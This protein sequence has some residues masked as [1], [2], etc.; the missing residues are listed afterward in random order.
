MAA[1]GAQSTQ[2]QKK[3]KEEDTFYIGDS[4]RR[5]H[6]E[7]D[8]MYLEGYTGYDWG[9]KLSFTV[10]ITYFTGNHSG[11]RFLHLTSLNQPSP[12]VLSKELSKVSQSDGIYPRN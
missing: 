5:R 2:D 12:S 4:S 7:R 3:I 10:G 11:P 8:N 6:R 9:D 1:A